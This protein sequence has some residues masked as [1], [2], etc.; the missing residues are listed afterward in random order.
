MSGHKTPYKNF[1]RRN[2]TYCVQNV[3]LE[4]YLRI[5]YSSVQKFYY[6]DL[7]TV[8]ERNWW[9]LIEGQKHIGLDKIT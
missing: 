6:L 4:R 7:S 2:V 9:T 5:I 3:I 8:V 1:S